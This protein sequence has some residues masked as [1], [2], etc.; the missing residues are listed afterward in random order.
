[1]SYVVVC[2]VA[3]VVSTLTLFSG[4][5]LG[6]L[7]MPAF[8]LFF[9]TPI[10][11]A[12]TALVH[13]ANNLFKLLLVG[14]HADPGVVVR[15][16]LPAG[17]GAVLGAGVLARVAEL[18]PLAVYDLAGRAR[19]V[20]PVKLTI[21]VLILGFALLEL[22]P[23]RRRLRFARR[24][25]MVGGLV[26]GFFGG[27][28][29]HQGAL[30]SVVLVSARL[31]KDAFVGTSVVAAVVVDVARLLVYGIQ[32]IPAEKGLSPLVVAA[33]AAALVGSFIGT[34]LLGAMTMRSIQL[35]VGAMLVLVGTG[36]ATGLF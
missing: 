14:R 4:F 13:L 22:L 11:I 18:P 24:H 3:F 8:A 35:M 27:L 10:A 26:S 16:A 19:E 6:T 25:L 33:T 29:G 5:G 36:L 15:F 21:G 12:A 9:R 32:M 1:M 23:R 31:D 30:R 34:R 17:A 20:T 7:L 28:S 2:T